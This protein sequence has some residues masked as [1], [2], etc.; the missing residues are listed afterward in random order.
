LCYPRFVSVRG[1][2]LMKSKARSPPTDSSTHC[3]YC[4]RPLVAVC[5]LLSAEQGVEPCI[6]APP[7]QRMIEHNCSN[8]L[9]LLSTRTRGSTTRHLWR[10]FAHHMRDK[11]VLHIAQ[12]LSAPYCSCCVARPSS[13]PQ[14]AA[15]TRAA[16]STAK[17]H[18][19]SLTSFFVLADSFVWYND[20]VSQDNAIVNTQTE[21]ITLKIDNDGTLDTLQNSMRTQR[22]EE[23]GGGIF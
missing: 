20:S 9:T 23:K 19:V 11:S 12:S 16:T 21:I 7:G 10:M 17:L 15:S 14:V 6:K 18:L 5:A 1:R 4:C 8:P 13:T 22:R 3:R 2:L